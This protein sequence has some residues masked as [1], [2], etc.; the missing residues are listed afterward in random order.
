MLGAAFEQWFRSASRGHGVS[1]SEAVAY[2]E[3][4]RSVESHLTMMVQSRSARVNGDVVI[5][6]M[7]REQGPGAGAEA[8]FPRFS[9]ACNH[10]Q[11]YFVKVN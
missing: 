2:T 1:E 9:L 4:R 5:T 3:T 10:G 8:S 11:P 6:Y 7:R